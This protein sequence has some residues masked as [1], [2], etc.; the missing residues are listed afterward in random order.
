VDK[1]PANVTTLWQRA[2]WRRLLRNRRKATRRLHDRMID[3]YTYFVAIYLNNTQMPQNIEAA[4]RF[5]RQIE[6]C[7]RRTVAFGPE[8]VRSGVSS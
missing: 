5:K 7:H 6:R 3:E 2:Q 1:G 4:W 8:T